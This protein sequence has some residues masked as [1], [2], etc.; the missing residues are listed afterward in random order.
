MV[1]GHSFSSNNS[2]LKGHE[3][4]I[5]RSGLFIPRTLDSG[6][7]S[8]ISC[9]D[10]LF[11]CLFVCLPFRVQLVAYGSSPT[12]QLTA[13]LDPLTSWERPGM[14]PA[15]S[16]LGSLPLSHNRNSLLQWFLRLYF[17]IL[18]FFL[19]RVARM[20]SVF[21]NQCICYTDFVSF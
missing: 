17:F 18:K 7:H 21:C 14:E 19:L 11:V 13:T 10:F 12:P 3:I 2:I 8:C 16:Y 4:C 1:I 20:I 9:N 5:C 15:S 6:V